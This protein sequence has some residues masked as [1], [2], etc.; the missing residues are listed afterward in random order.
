MAGKEVEVRGGAGRRATGRPQ[1]QVRVGGRLVDGDVQH[2]R[3]DLV[4]RGHAADAGD[5]HI[6][7]DV[8]P[9][10]AVEAAGSVTR[11]EDPG[12]RQGVVA[13]AD[14]EPSEYVGDGRRGALEVVDA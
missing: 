2:D 7:A 8:L 3:A 14:R 1:R 13:R 6:V 10:L 5:D 12:R 9:E 4:G 11:V